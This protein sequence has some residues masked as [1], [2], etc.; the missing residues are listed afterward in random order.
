[1][2]DIMKIVKSPEESGLLIKGISETIN[3][4]AKEQKGGF[5]PILLETLAAIILGNTLIGK[6]VIRAG[7]RVIRASQ[8]S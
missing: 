4:E 7:E 2:E 5:I 1:M 3:S 8:N 6:E